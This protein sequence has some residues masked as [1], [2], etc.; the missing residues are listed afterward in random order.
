MKTSTQLA[1]TAKAPESV[2]YAPPQELSQRRHLLSVTREGSAKGAS[3]LSI[4][5]V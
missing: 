4:C 5:P 3:Q 2:A 1:L